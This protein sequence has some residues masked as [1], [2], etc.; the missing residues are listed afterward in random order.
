M[1][2]TFRYGGGVARFPIRFSRAGRAMALLGM[3]PSV[4]Y[5][6]LGDGSVTVRMGWAFRST[7][8]RAQVA[9]IAVDDDRVLGWG[10]HGWR[11]TWLVN[12]SS[13]GMLRIELE[14]EARASVAGFPVKLS[15]LRVSVEDPGT[16]I[17]RLRPS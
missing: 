10:V 5:V 1:P 7:F 13:A 6:E 3:G 15:K 2:G 9:S 12:G 14:P 4:S 16:L 17:T 8:D 11:G